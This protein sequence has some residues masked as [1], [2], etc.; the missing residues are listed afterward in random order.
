MN[1]LIKNK[2]NFIALF[3]YEIHNIYLE[4]FHYGSLITKRLI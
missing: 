2:I 3:I 1:K 4:Y